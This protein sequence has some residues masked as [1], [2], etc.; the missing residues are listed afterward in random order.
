MA[1]RVAQLHLKEIQMQVA[2]EPAENRQT[3][4]MWS[5]LVW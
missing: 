2:D 5:Q 1:G 4:D 3:M